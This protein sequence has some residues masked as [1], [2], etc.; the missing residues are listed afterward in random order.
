MEDDGRQIMSV[1]HVRQFA[2]LKASAQWNYRFHSQNE[3]SECY[4]FHKAVMKITRN[5]LRYMYKHKR[6]YY[7]VHWVGR[8]HSR[9]AMYIVIVCL[10][11]CLPN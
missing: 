1:P 10:F 9:S 7:Y 2:Y 3:S 4:L 11:I 6:P 8:A 5:N